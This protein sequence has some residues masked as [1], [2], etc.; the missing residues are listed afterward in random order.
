MW[1]LPVTL[2]MLKQGP[3]N[4]RHQD[5]RYIYERLS[6]T[7]FRLTMRKGLAA[8]IRDLMPVHL[9]RAMEVSY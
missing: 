6:V 2:S 7:Q 3:G 5:S 9:P 4:K 8:V 1:L